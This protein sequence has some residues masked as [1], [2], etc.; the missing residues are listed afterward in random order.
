MLKKVDET[1][2]TR[3]QKLHLYS[4][5]ICPHVIWDMAIHNFPISWVTKNPEAIAMRYL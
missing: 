3:Q 2:V 4:H 1:L 5:G